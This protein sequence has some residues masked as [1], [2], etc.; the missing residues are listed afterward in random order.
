[1]KK[2]L[3]TTV[4][5]LAAT[6]AFAKDFTIKEVTNPDGGKKPYYFSPDKLTIQPGDTV[7]FENAQDDTHDVMFVGVPKTV[8]EMIMSKMMEKKGDKFSY[9]FT[10]P[11]TYQF[12]CHPHEA[13]GMKGTII[14]GQASKPGETK[15]V[16]HHDMAAKLEGGSDHAAD[17]KPAAGSDVQATGQVVSVDAA[18]HSIKL[19]HDPIK[20]LN[21]PT[22]TM[23][24]TADSSVNLSGYQPGDAVSFA[25]KPVGKDDY[26][27]TSLKKQ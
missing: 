6:P 11:G 9:T 19:K 27:L 12:H 3:L 15:K 4:L 16:S 18:K 22:M 17:A 25:L 13:L 2:L 20:A 5:M 26:T 14:V 8:D 21:W 24:F 1:M 10:V 7:V 23:T